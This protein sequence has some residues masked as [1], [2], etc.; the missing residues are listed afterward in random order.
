MPFD[1]LILFLSVVFDAVIVAD[2]GRHRGNGVLGVGLDSQREQEPCRDTED[3]ITFFPFRLHGV[4]SCG[5][6]FLS[7]L[8]CPCGRQ[9]GVFFNL[10]CKM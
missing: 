3:E 9:D 1:K 8:S 5:V 7:R 6:N 2:P 4:T 10:K